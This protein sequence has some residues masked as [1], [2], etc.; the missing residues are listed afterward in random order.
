MHRYKVAALFLIGAGLVACSALKSNVAVPAQHPEE[1]PKGRPMCS[2]E[3]CHGRTHEDL[4][5]ARFD[6]SRSF[7]EGGHRNE[8]YQQGK[9]C[10]MCHEQS[11]CNDCH[12]TRSELK[13][14]EKDSTGTYRIYPHRGDYLTRHRI[15]ARVDPMPCFRCHG[16]P[17][18]SKAC[19]AC[20]GK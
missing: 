4:P 8:A 15:D 1:L 2:A 14:S 3:D 7:A 19:V 12:V 16:N 6:H 17:K 20:H 10:A 13:P 9:V 18:S 11:F 5:F